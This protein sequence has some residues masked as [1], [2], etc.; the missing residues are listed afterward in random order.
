MVEEHR[1]DLLERDEL[2]DVDRLGLA[3]L[4][5]GELVV[6]EEDPLAVRHLVSVG[7]LLPRHLLALLDADPVRLDRSTVLLVQLAEVQVQ[8][9]HGRQHRH[10]HVHQAEAQRA[11]PQGPGHQLRLLLRLPDLLEDERELRV[12]LDLPS[13]RLELRRADD[14]ERRRDLPPSWRLAWSAARRS[15]EGSGLG[16]LGGWISSPAALRL[17]RSRTALRYSSLS[18]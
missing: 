5:G 7:D 15:S 12:D 3:R 9:A 2:L 11:A 4:G 13:P 8:V 1:I 16:S 17:I 10:R 18:S 14:L 6:G